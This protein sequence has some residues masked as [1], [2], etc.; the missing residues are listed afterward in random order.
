MPD[1]LLKILPW[2]ISGLL[3]LGVAWGVMKTTVAGLAKSLD[4]DRA[5]NT[6]NYVELKEGVKEIS[7]IL[8]ESTSELRQ[9]R[10][11]DRA[12]QSRRNASFDDRMT[13]IDERNNLISGSNQKLTESFEV[14]AGRMEDLT[15]AVLADIGKKPKS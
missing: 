12:E 1:V 9:M 11:N 8:L 5:V 10:E 14:M 13:A 15:S 2:A 6:S 7:T 3:V 4:N